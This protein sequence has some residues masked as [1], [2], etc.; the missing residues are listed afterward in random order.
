VSGPAPVAVTEQL[1]VAPT[2]ANELVG[3]SVMT[4]GLLANDLSVNSA[5]TVTAAKI[6]DILGA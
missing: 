6:K 3:W 4:G 2:A 1:T 5:R